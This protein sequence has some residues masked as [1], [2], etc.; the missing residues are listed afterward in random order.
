MWFIFGMFVGTLLT[1]YIYIQKKDIKNGN[2]KLKNLKDNL[3]GYLNETNKLQEQI[4]N[5]EK[6]IRK[7]SKELQAAISDEKI[8]ELEQTIS[9]LVKQSMRPKN[10]TTP[11]LEYKAEPKIQYQEEHRSEPQPSPEQ[12][13]WA[14]MQKIFDIVQTLQ[15]G[16]A[17]YCNYNIHT[18]MLSATRDNAAPYI[19]MSLSDN[20]EVVLPNQTD[21]FRS[22]ELPGGAYQCAEDI[23]TEDMFMLLPCIVR[24][25]TIIKPGEIR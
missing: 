24:A 21:I 4:D 25:G 5:L 2:S 3:V 19:M 8:Q 7:V 13:P 17:R 9:V 22:S 20:A 1:I 23:I 18:C 16:N 14:S 15:Q 10:Q 11:D 12:E 6:D